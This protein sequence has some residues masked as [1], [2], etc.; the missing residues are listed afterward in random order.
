MI[1]VCVYFTKTVVQYLPVSIR[2]ETL[3][4]FAGIASDNRAHLVAC[5]LFFCEPRGMEISKA[6]LMDREQ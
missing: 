5:A 1:I 2:Q 4:R 6:L 3:F